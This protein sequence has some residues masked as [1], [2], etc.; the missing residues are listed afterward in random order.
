MT[1]RATTD[2]GSN[3]QCSP[4]R[5]FFLLSAAAGR[6]TKVRIRIKTAAGSS[7]RGLQRRLKT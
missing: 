3:A 4:D 7:Y 1:K 2:G 5:G 6:D